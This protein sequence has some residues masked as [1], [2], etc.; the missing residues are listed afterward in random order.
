MYLS[1]QYVHGNL[2]LCHLTYCNILEKSI[3]EKSNDL[4]IFLN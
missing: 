4:T 1:F 2:V 3:S